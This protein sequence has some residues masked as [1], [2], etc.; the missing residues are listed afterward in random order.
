MTTILKSS[1]FESS[2][3]QF[4][5]LKKNKRGGG[6]VYMKYDNPS[7]KKHTVYLQTPKMYCP[8]GASAFKKDELADGEVPK[9]SLQMS[10]RGHEENQSLG[11]LKTKLE[12]FD[13]HIVSEVLKNKE[14]QS[15]LGLAGKK[16][17]TREMVEML[18]TS[19]VKEPVDEKYPSTLNV[20]LPVKWGTEEFQTEVFDKTKSKVELS[21][22]TIEEVIPARCEVRALLQI[23]AA[24]VVGGKFGITVRASQLVVYP[25]EALTGYSFLD[26]DDDSAEDEDSESESEVD[27]EQESEVE[28]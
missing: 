15:A 2:R 26:S 14:L 4:A 22:E 6:V 7:G 3:V 17:L 12:S 20:K 9:Y 10:F 8:F 11:E 5:P 24:W 21:Y 16:K 25:T 18:H 27:T 19:M 23:S 13:E 28:E 1:S